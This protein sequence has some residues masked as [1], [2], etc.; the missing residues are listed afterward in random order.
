[1]PAK[2]E[3]PTI[4]PGLQAKSLTAVDDRLLRLIRRTWDP[5]PLTPATL[6][7]EVEWTT[8]VEKALHHGVAELLCRSLRDLPA[9]E[10]P[11]DLLDAA[12]TFLENAEARGSVLVAQL[13]DILDVLAAEGI[14]AL[15]FKGPALGV[16]AHG[17]ATIRPSRDI[18][19]LV[20]K[21]D[22][23]RT[24]T[25]LGRLGYRL[26]ESLSPRIMAACYESY[27][28]DILFAT[29]RTAVEPHWAFVPSAL[30][31]DVDMNDI[32]SRAS[33]L[34]IAGRVVHS[35]SLEDMLLMACLHGS[36]EKW[37]RLL[38]VADVA[39]LIRRH[40]ALDWNALMERAERAGIG[41]MLLLGLA[42][43]EDLFSSA[44][45]AAVS[46]AI[47]R[48]PTCLRLVQQSKQHL[49]APGAPEGSFQHVSRYHLRAR[50]R[51]GDRVRYV[52]RTITTP[53]FNHYRMVK[54]P[55]SLL[56]GYVLV[57][58]VHDYLHLPLWLLGKGRWWRRAHNSIPDQTV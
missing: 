30:A 2:A 46:S 58:L 10:I 39:A 6:S 55:D 19:I 13:F 40:P 18:D 35:L 42:L 44:L 8:M 51:I 26:G 38:W 36:K 15:P 14:P 52:W 23:D 24:V 53:R 31:V 11:E 12:G 57:K 47:R 48:D 41:R 1:M 27:G 9:A 22:M 34:G 49:F 17:S 33:P 56:F 21:S 43:A 5:S 37:W 50:E 16:L 7:S 20:R 29:G 32:W 28:Q 45:P 25:A 4:L 3:L 54:L